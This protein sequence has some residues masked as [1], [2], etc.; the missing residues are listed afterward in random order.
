MNVN[1]LVWY[2]TREL[3]QSPPHFVKCTTPL[4]DKSLMW[5]ITKLQGRFSKD[6]VADDDL[7][8][9]FVTTYCISFEDSAEAML[10][11]LRWSGTK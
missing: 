1:P 6:Q 4:T 5:V 2:S 11:E 3:K 7:E 10:Y 9:V 8:F